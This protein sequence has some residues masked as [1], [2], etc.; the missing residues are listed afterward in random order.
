MGY[1]LYQPIYA[2]IT[3]KRRAARH[4]RAAR[5]R[6]RVEEAQRYLEERYGYVENEDSGDRWTLNFEI[7]L[8][9]RGRRIDDDGYL[10][11][12]DEDKNDEDEEDFNEQRSEQQKDDDDDDGRYDFK[13]DTVGDIMRSLGLYMER[14]WDSEVEDWDE[15]MKLETFI[16]FSLY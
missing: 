14:D 5:K 11:D 9:A 2:N 13:I 10:S 12:F 1:T 8:P 3:E 7:D 16:P 6:V 15:E 4:R